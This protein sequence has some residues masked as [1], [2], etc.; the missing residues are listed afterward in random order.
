MPNTN[1]YDDIS[2]SWPVDD[3]DV[4]ASLTL[5]HGQ[6]PFPAVIMVAGSGP[7]DRNWNSPLI[8]GANGSAALLAQVLAETGFIALRYDKRASRPHARECYTFGGQ[9]QH[10]GSSGGIGRRCA[11]VG[12]SPTS[13]TFLDAETVETIT[14]WLKANASIGRARKGK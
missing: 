2:V 6:G 11:I 4:N 1:S 13:D 3:I 12:Q 7:T 14:F 5:P 9:D 8:P 10:A